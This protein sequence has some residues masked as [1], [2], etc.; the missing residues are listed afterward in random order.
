M[1]SNSVHSS[2][3]YVA[4]MAKSLISTYFDPRGRA[5]DQPNLISK[6]A[7]ISINEFLQK[8]RQNQQV[9]FGDP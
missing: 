1:N 3:R 4:T 6:G 8:Q 2:D 5:H 7:N 9:S